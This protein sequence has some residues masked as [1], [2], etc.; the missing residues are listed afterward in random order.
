MRIRKLWPAAL[1]CLFSGGCRTTLD[2]L[3]AKEEAADHA[4]V[5]ASVKQ[6]VSRQGTGEKPAAEKVP[7]W[8][9]WLPKPAPSKP[10]HRDDTLGDRKEASDIAARNN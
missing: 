4:A 10:E 6:A 7:W 5:Q 8:K 9:A 2:S 1:L 3:A